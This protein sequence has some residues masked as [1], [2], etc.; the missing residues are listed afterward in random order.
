MLAH[1]YFPPSRLR[2][3]LSTSPR[4]R[5][6]PSVGRLGRTEILP[7]SDFSVKVSPMPPFRGRLLQ[8]VIFGI[9]SAAEKNQLV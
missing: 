1:A 8:V 9:L 5:R 4:L 3:R 7:I 6:T 2:T